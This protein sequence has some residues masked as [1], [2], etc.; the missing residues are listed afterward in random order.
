MYVGTINVAASSIQII[1]QNRTAG[2]YTNNNAW[3]FFN[4]NDTSMN[5]VNF[6]QNI[7]Y[8]FGKDADP[9]VYKT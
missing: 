6:I 9:K 2:R 7:N 5:R 4:A 1:L 3:Q 8:F